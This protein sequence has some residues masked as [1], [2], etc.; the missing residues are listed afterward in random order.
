MTTITVLYLYILL[1]GGNYTE[2]QASTMVCIAELESSFR[3]K[4][5]NKNKNGSIDYGLFQINDR[6]WLKPCM[7]TVDNL[8]TIK[9]IFSNTAALSSCGM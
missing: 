4:A 5:I 6:W 7:T 9:S 3:V 8:L 1:I 2:R